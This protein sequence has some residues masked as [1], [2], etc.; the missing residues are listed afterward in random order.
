MLLYFVLLL[1][2][3]FH[4]QYI[5][6]VSYFHIYAF[7]FCDDELYMLKSNKTSVLF[8]SM[9]TIE[10]FS[11]LICI[12]S[13]TPKRQQRKACGSDLRLYV[14]RIYLPKLLAYICKRCGARS[15]CS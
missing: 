5:P 15:D 10:L 14:C 8:C 3:V 11:L 4:S 6:Y 7:L 12:Q 13:E 9:F 1:K 2:N